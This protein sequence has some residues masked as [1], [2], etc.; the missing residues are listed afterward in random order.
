MVERPQAPADA[1]AEGSTRAAERPQPLGPDEA[2]RVL[3]G[4][5]V[6]AQA[7]RC[8]GAPR[9]RIACLIAARYEGD[10]EAQKLAGDLY[11][12]FQIVVGQGEAET[13]DGA[14]RGIIRLVPT[15]PVGADRK[16]L[17]WLHSAFDT[18]FRFFKGLEARAPGKKIRYRFS[19]LTVRFVRSLDGKRTPSGYASGW[20]Y[21]YNVNGSLVTSAEAILNL[22]FHEIFHLNDFDP[23]EGTVGAP[24][25]PGALGADVDR[26][27]SRC[28]TRA[29]CLQPFAPTDLKVRGGTYYAF[30]PGNRI[31]AEYAA[32]LSTR[33]MDEHRGILGMA[34]KKPAFKCGPKENAASWQALVDTYFGG[35]DLVPPCPK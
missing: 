33:Y 30:Q 8:E 17:V 3:F 18:I 12:R 7:S 23:P 28:G 27:V 19:P 10:P 6:P 32:E 24:W 9:E 31:V 21:N 13:M 2:K 29:A 25:S 35:V 14:Y 26:I 15:L 16:H 1:G 20:T 22:A 11:S 5:S 4:S 34:P